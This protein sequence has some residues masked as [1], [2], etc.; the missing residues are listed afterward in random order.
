MPM[1]FERLRH[2]LASVPPPETGDTPS[3][4]APDEVRFERAYTRRS[5]A[6]S[7]A[8]LRTALDAPCPAHDA[9]AGAFCWPHARGL[10]WPRFE[11]GM[12]RAPMPPL[13]SEPPELEPAATA[14]RHAHRN[15]RLRER[16]SARA[17]VRR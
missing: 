7:R 4:V 12:T 13:V 10:C 3:R 11:D 5:L 8:L 9:C 15:Q 6:R 1:N 16:R 17:G 14:V 2:H